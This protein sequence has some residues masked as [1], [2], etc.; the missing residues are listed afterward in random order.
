[1]QYKAR[2]DEAE[3]RHNELKARMGDGS[4]ANDPDEYRKVAKAQSELDELVPKYR[5]WKRAQRELEDARVMLQDIDPD[6]REMAQLEVTRLEPEVT[7][8]EQELQL[9]ELR[10]HVPP[11]GEITR[12]MTNLSIGL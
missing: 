6:L 10:V 7:A 3:A 11:S 2:L 8:L 4:L 5:A 1:M 9:F 12:R